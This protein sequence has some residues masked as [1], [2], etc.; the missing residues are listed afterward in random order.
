MR[1]VTAGRAKMYL[2]ELTPLSVQKRGTREV[3]IM[4]KKEK[5]D[6]HEEEGKKEE[7]P[8]KI[9]SWPREKSKRKKK[10]GIR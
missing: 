10:R 8:K 6:I 2:P 3:E 5:K 1:D 7:T 9:R 4:K